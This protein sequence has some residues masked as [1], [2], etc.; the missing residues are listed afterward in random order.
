MSRIRWGILSTA[1]IGI[2][3]VIPAIQRA[4]R[5]E[6]VAIASRNVEKAEAVAAPLGIPR[7]HG[8]YGHLLNDPDIDAV[9]IAL[10]I[11]LH[12][13]WIEAA[14]KAGKHVLC[15]AR[16][17]MDAAA[18]GETELAIE[19]E[20]A[21]PLATVMSRDI[22]KAVRVVDVVEPEPPFDA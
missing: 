7:A 20:L 2:E 15:E 14:A 3:K 9:Y 11:G 16:M 6:V 1:K 22:G 5:C 12:A 4:E 18:R 17:A 8:S 19:A 21:E 13:R 10:P